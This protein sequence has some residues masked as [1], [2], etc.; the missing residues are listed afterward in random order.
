MTPQDPTRRPYT[1]RRDDRR[2][3]SRGGSPPPRGAPG[4]ARSG[5]LT[6]ERP[7]KGPARPADPGWVRPA[8]P[9][10]KNPA[11]RAPRGDPARRLGVTLL[12]IVFVLSLFAGRLIQLQGMESG[13]Y[14]QLASR[15]LGKTSPLPALRGSITGANGQVLAMT[16][17]TYL[18]SADPT[19]ITADKQQQVA[20]AL[21][22]PLEMTPAAILARLQHPTSRQYVVL[23]NGV[24]AQASAQITALGLPGVKQAASYARSYPAGSV[25]ASI[26][27]FTGTS[28]GVLTGAAGLELA[29]NSLL[30]GS[31]G[32]RAGADQHRRPADPAGGQP[33]PAGGKRQQPAPHHQ[34]AAAVRGRAGLRQ[35]GQEDQ[36][37]QLHGGDHPAQ[38]RGRAGHGAVPDV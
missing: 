22:G 38:D 14:R 17:A 15:Q 29:E 6:P 34:P 7:P 10:P 20:D 2:P 8:R 28:H 12:A 3:R 30:A 27:G 18:V 32:Q 26:V 5:L 24:S 35:T 23:A 11:R 21:S 36:G 19:Q 16:V 9:R 13:T 25:A 1:G 33:Q 31:S 37:G 4:P